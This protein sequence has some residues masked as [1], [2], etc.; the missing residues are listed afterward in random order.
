MA[1]KRSIIGTYG[2]W[3]FK[4]KQLAKLRFRLLSKY[5]PFGKLGVE[6]MGKVKTGNSFPQLTQESKLAV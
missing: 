3:T 2:T 5:Q 1:I 4:K 6:Q